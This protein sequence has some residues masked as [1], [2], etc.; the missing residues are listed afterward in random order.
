MK[1]KIGADHAGF[2]LKETLKD[3]LIS[4]GHEV[5]DVGVYSTDSADYPEPAANVAKAVAAGEAQRGVLVCGSG[6][7]VCMTANR[8]HGA[9]AVLSPTVEHAKLGREHNNANVVCLGE[10]LTPEDLALDILDTFLNTPF[11]GGR[12][13]RRVDKIDSLT[14]E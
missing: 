3:R 13:Q 10:R 5:D 2:N 4:L 6:I 11:E 8:I 14:G 9:R 12:H 7:G 1:I